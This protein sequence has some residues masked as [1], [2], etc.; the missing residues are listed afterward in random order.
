MTRWITAA[1]V[2]LA[3]IPALHAAEVSNFTLDN[4]LEVV[5]LEDRRAPAV[6]HM[7]WYRVGASDEPR[8][9]SG[10]A[11]FLE[12]LMFKG[13]ETV[14]SGEFSRIVAAN[15][16][17]D[18]AFTAHDYTGYFQRVASDRLDVMMEMEADRMVNLVIDPVAMETERE[19]VLEERNQ[20][21]EN[22]PGSLFSEQRQ[23][24]QFL[25]HP[26]GQPIVGWR[27]EIEAITLDDLEAFYRANYAPNNAVLIVAGDAGPE[28][29]RA[30]AERTYGVIPANPAISPRDRV[31][32]PPHLAERRLRFED[33]R[34]SQPYVVRS[35][36]APERDA[37][38]QET[39]A[40]L[41]LLA[42]VLG[43]DSATS[44][45]GQT[46]Q[47]EQGSAIY[48]SAFYSG[49]SLDDT[50]FGLVA[51]PAPGVSLEELEAAMDARL[52]SFVE[53]GV[54]AAQLERLKTQI[55][56]SLIYSEDNLG[57]LARRYGAALTSGLTVEDVQAW[58]DILAA[59][60]EDDILAAAE[61][62]F[63]RNRAVT[64]YMMAPDQAAA[65][66]V[67]Q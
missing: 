49:T 59:V 10:I 27:H 32:E 18:N 56:A 48:T 67:M 36:L 24:A 5:V 65:Q 12:H 60:T 52:R 34:V 13:T 25:N 54:D 7:L 3:S 62:L 46:L 53:E 55:R 51:V 61:L 8:G 17:R 44:V 39:A 30:L 35:Y 22:E 42:E 64:G 41:T 43:G 9:L 58:P 16:G 23:A 63:N 47:F 40:A 37:G 29:V 19:V 33:A 21:T 4:G 1:A 31:D 20:R 6:V 66:E 11:H 26:Y 28:E 14:A 57:S 45:L 2:W 38:D 15:G 50:T